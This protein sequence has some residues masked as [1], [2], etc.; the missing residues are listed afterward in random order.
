MPGEH[1]ALLQPAIRGGLAGPRGV[2][3]A[4]EVLAVFRQALEIYPD[5]NHRLTP[6]LIKITL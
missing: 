6:Q 4:V 5:I 2:S 1:G 3:E